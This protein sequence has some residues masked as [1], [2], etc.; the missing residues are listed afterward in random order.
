MLRVITHSESFSIQT[1]NSYIIVD[2][3]DSKFCLDLLKFFQTIILR[4]ADECV[5]R[6]LCDTVKKH[7]VARGA[8]V[9]IILAAYDK[10]GNGNRLERTQRT[11][12]SLG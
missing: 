10:D 11:S 1:P 6:A 5:H 7:H 2:A 9:I 8:N 4:N 3:T 12:S